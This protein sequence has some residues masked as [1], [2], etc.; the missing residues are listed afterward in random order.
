MAYKN[1]RRDD[2]RED[3]RGNRGNDRKFAHPFIED[4]DWE[5]GDKAGRGF[6]RGERRERGFGER[7]ENRF[8]RDDNRGFLPS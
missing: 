1:D 5:E 4:G 2:R 7:R 8:G 3:R 6:D